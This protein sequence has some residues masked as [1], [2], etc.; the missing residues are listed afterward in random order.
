MR[1]GYGLTYAQGVWPDTY[2]AMRSPLHF[3]RPAL[4]L[5]LSVLVACSPVRRGDDDDGGGDDGFEPNDSA[6][7]A[8]AISCGETV[9][10]TGADPDWYRFTVD[11]A[12]EVEAAVNW[13]DPDAA[14]AVSLAAPDGADLECT[15]AS[16]SVNCGSAWFGPG[17]YLLGVI[18]TNDAGADYAIA[19]TCVGSTGDD[20][21][22]T[23]DDDDATEPPVVLEWSAPVAGTVDW[24]YRASLRFEF[25]LPPSGFE[26][27]LTTSA[28]SPVETDTP[29]QDDRD[30]TVTPSAPLQPNAAY[31]VAVSW[32]GGAAEIEFS[33]SS[34]GTP[35]SN[36]AGL[37]EAAFLTDFASALFLEPQGLGSL[38]QGQLSDTYMLCDLLPGTEFGASSQPG[39]LYRF[40][41]GD[42]NGGVEQELCE[43]TTSLGSSDAGTWEDPFFSIEVPGSL[44]MSMQGVDMVIEEVTMTG[45]YSED[46]DAIG[47]GTF[48]GLLDTRSLNELLNSE[49]PNAMCDL[50]L[51]TAGV[52]CEA[53]PDGDVYCVQYYAINV[54]ASLLP[55]V[56]IV[57]R[58]ATEIANDPACN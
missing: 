56:T 38:L 30:V 10:A 8:A 16:L 12:G 17:D 51:E 11:A 19:L 46:G 26:A 13:T 21:D 3:A 7:A 4:L 20:D 5:A 25:N 6:D 9:Q 41:V 18:P 52:E 31:E 15:S 24:F 33:T 29:T 14:F 35:V 37:I 50:L 48:E 53:C 57:D 2:W 55:G 23:G 32:D 28:G 40:A 39:L 58:T 54:Q 49:D 44:T 34:Y 43:E 22:A 45:A 27:T 1:R 42:D 36:P 47:G